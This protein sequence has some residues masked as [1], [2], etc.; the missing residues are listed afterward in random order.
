MNRSLNGRDHVYYLISPPHSTQ[1]LGSSALARHRTHPSVRPK[2]TV[3]CLIFPFSY[4]QQI[5]ASIYCVSGHLPS[6]HLLPA[7][8]Y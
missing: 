4:V 6:A 5:T 3:V 1:E 2:P 8:I 7:S